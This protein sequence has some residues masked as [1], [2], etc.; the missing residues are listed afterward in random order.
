M[1]CGLIVVSV[2]YRLTRNGQLQRRFEMLGM[3]DAGYRLTQLTLEYHRSL[4]ST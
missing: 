2:G 3:L 1:T 4:I